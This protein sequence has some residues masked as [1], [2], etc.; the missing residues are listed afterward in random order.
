MTAEF[1]AEQFTRKLCQNLNLEVCGS[2]R[3]GS[4][5]FP[6]GWKSVVE[7][8]LTAMRD[9][10]VQIFA[11]RNDHGLLDVRA[12]AEPESELRVYRA[13]LVYQQWASIICERC[14]ARGS[15][16]ILG[17]KVQVLCSDCMEKAKEE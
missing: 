10:K 13:I 4:F 3:V 11:I 17:G 15:K 5:D 14:S 16:I 2:F 9:R 7:R 8:M 1:N 12:V 6:E